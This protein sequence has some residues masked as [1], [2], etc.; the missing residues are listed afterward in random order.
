M[1]G[2]VLVCISGTEKTLDG[3]R[4][5][6]MDTGDVETESATNDARAYNDTADAHG[7]YEF[8]RRVLGGAYGDALNQTLE[9]TLLFMKEASGVPV[10]LSMLVLV[11]EEREA[12]V[13]DQDPAEPA[14][15][16]RHEVGREPAHQICSRYVP[17]V[18]VE[19]ALND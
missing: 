8:F 2:R 18:C 9:R 13:I 3:A 12:A 10:M 11:F 1:R 19:L 5:P 17:P 16:C 15:R 4:H 6:L 7:P 14:A